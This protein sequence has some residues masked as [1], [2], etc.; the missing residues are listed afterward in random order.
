MLFSALI[1][2]PHGVTRK[3]TCN[4]IED[5]GGR[6][7]AEVETVSTTTD[8]LERREPDLLVTE[9]D[10]ASGSGLEILAQIR[11]QNLTVAPLILTRRQDAACVSASFQLGARGFALK[12]DPPSSFETAVRSVLNG[13]THLSSSIPEGL[14]KPP[15]S[16][17]E[18]ALLS[19][20][21]D[22]QCLE[23]AKLKDALGLLEVLTDRERQVLRLTAEGL[24]CREIGDRLSISTRT[25][26]KYQEQIRG[27]LCVDNKVEM[28]RF[29]FQCELAAP[30]PPTTPPIGPSSGSSA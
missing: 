15:S 26:E 1:A 14:A 5:L 29:A 30:N 10:L 27:T 24:T 21:L 12:T 7:V 2:D 9:L 19:A 25:A 18:D 4:L 3:G 28:V 17:D 8:L 6:V 22:G 23:T 11:V 20:C 13:T 16:L